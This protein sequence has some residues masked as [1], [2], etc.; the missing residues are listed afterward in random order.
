MAKVIENE[1]ARRGISYDHIVGSDCVTTNHFAAEGR[2]SGIASDVGEEVE[3]VAIGCG[4]AARVGNK[5]EVHSGVAV[6][7]REVHATTVGC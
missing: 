3:H 6:E 2:V 7:D 1:S 5:G 4:I